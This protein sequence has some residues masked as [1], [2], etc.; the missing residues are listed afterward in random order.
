MVF[1]AIDEDNTPVTVP[2]LTVS[3][4]QGE[5]LHEAAIEDAPQ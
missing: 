4:E 3:T 1:V 2:D 5:R